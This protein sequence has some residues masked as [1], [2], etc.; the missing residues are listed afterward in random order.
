[1][2]G[3]K[4]NVPGRGLIFTEF[5]RFGRALFHTGPAFDAVLR[6]GGIGFAV[7]QSVDFIR[8]DVDTI[9]TPGASLTSYDRIH[10]CLTFII[11]SGRSRIPV[12][13]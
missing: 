6:A 8:T 12:A 11:G 4:G 5:D 2:N 3:K 7:L 9:S 1:M 10:L 13:G